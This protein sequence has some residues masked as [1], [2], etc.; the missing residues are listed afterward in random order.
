MGRGLPLAV[1]VLIGI[2]TALPCGKVASAVGSPAVLWRFRTSATLAAPVLV[3]GVLY[4]GAADGFVY[5]VEP[6]TGY[7]LWGASADTPAA[8]AM[9]VAG[10]TVYLANGDFATLDARTGEERLRLGSDRYRL[11]ALTESGGVVYGGGVA[12]GAGFVTALDDFTGSRVWRADTIGIVAAPPAVTAEAAYVGTL[13]GELYAF[14]PGSGA[15]RWRAPAAGGV[16][17]SPVVA[18][19]TV[20][21]ATRGTGTAATATPEAE[22]GALQAVET[23]T[24]R[25]RWRVALG[26]RPEA[27]PVAAEGVVLVA[28]GG[29][30]AA[31][32]A[33]T[34][35]T[36]W[37]T[38]I[39]ER[40]PAAPAVSEGTLY[41]ADPAGGVVALAAADGTERWRLALP[42]PATVAPVVAGG[43]AYVA[44]GSSLYAVTGG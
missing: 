34:G 15:V 19:E 35:A 9:A 42:D 38:A 4:V 41:V 40:G 29:R 32:D 17:G 16:V 13:A 20:Y 5:A 33:A 10:D 7:A 6:T 21:V 44:A 18:G 31:H 14:D 3:E 8:T 23:A 22:A 2:T 11:T 28:G 36:R 25:I 24:G 37:T 27:T 43:I 1:A 12:G 26:A 30:L 39:G